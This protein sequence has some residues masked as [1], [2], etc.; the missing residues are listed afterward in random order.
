MSDGDFSAIRIG[1]RVRHSD[2]TVG[3]ITWANAAAVKIEW[4]DGERVTW[5]RAELGS[6]GLTVVDEDQDTEPQAAG[7]SAEQPEETAPAV[8]QAVTTEAA[9][10]SE[11]PAA[12]PAEQP[13][14]DTTAEPPAAERPAKERRVRTAPAKGS[15]KLSALD[16]AAKVLQEAGQPMNCQEMV[17]AMVEKGLWSS[18]NGKTPA[19][20]LYSAILRE[21]KMKGAESRFEKTDRGRFAR[22]A[23]A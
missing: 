6:K 4:T 17:K 18:P 7:E 11:T 10:E 16:A 9:P 21:L 23:K 8:E 20:T 13:A 1:T 15:K 14:A 3:R 19:A 5:K 22:T 12:E 2:G